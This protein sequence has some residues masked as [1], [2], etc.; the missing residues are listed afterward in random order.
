MV[1]R[2]GEDQQSPSL[3]LF[4]CVSWWGHTCTN[5][6]MDCWCTCRTLR[7]WCKPYCM[8]TSFTVQ[9]HS[10]CNANADGWIIPIETCKQAHLLPTALVD[11][12]GLADTALHVTAP[13]HTQHTWTTVCTHTLAGS[14][15][16]LTGWNSLS[17]L[18]AFRHI[19]Q[20]LS[21]FC[22]IHRY[23]HFLKTAPSRLKARFSG[24]VHTLM[25]PSVHSR[26][27]CPSACTQFY[28]VHSPVATFVHLL[29]YIEAITALHSC[30]SGLPQ[31]GLFNHKIC[32][33][34]LFV[35]K[36]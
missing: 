3:P 30:G 7:H 29:Q 4:C 14:Y 35:W 25:L 26:F 8:H 5:P 13:H 9:Q 1:Y 27:L 12:G 28:R 24:H 32:F 17:Q 15:L 6:Y 2:W 31:N 33:A 10:A 18:T 16:P 19:S 23:P 22:Y 34:S 36:K 11:A 20:T 21:A